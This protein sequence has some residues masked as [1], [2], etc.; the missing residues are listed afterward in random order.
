MKITG[1][2]SPAFYNVGSIFNGMSLNTLRSIIEYHVLIGDGNVTYQTV[3]ERDTPD[4]TFPALTMSSRTVNVTH[5]YES[6]TRLLLDADV[7]DGDDILIANGNLISMDVVL[8]PDYILTGERYPNA[9]SV[10]VGQKLFANLGGNATSMLPSTPSPSSLSPS[11]AST[12]SSAT[13]PQ[14]SSLSPSKEGSVGAEVSN[15]SLPLEIDDGKPSKELDVEKEGPRPE[16]GGETVEPELEG[17]TIEPEMPGDTLALAPSLALPEVAPSSAPCPA[18]STN[19]AEKNLQGNSDDDTG[20]IALNK[21]NDSISGNKSNFTQDDNPAGEKA[22]D[23]LIWNQTSLAVTGWRYNHEKDFSMRL[24]YQDDQ[25]Y[26]QILAIESTSKDSWTP[27]T[28]FVKAKQ[29]TPLADETG[30][31]GSPS[32]QNITPAHDTRLA[33]YWPSVTY[34][35]ADNT[36]SEVQYNCTNSAI[37]CWNSNNLKRAGPGPSATLAMGSS[38]RNLN[39]ILLSYHHEGGELVNSSW[40][41]NTNMWSSKELSH[42][43]LRSH[44]ASVFAIPRSH[45]GDAL[46]F[47]VLYQ[48]SD[49]SDISWLWK[50]GGPWGAQTMDQAL[51][52][53]MRGTSI[54]CLTQESWWK[55]TLVADLEISRCYFFGQEGKLRSVHLVDNVWNDLGFVKGIGQS[56]WA[57]KRRF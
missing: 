32:A 29:G 40:S 48:D 33:S 18:S 5:K 1:P 15:T 20:K 4:W 11:S 28:K 26:L 51:K 21:G 7:P 12:P 56:L 27:G 8:D 46:N 19:D 23:N 43:I 2:K 3:I 25:G 50:Q 57:T 35:N 13:I 17:R 38:R 16:L 52:G 34:Q 55:K 30:F 31:S 9:S 47:H 24:F 39:G 41:N 42:S 22:S 6:D 14:T 44:F 54:A 49:V 10:P 37:N 53:A 36:F 45:D